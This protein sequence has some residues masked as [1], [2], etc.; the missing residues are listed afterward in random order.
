MKF[1]EI[2]TE[3]FITRKKGVHKR[4]NVR[5]G[6]N[7]VKLK[8]YFI[9]YY[10]VTTGLV[11]NFLLRYIMLFENSQAQITIS[12]STRKSK[13]SSFY[14]YVSKLLCVNIL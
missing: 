1:S 6:R 5:S 8:L 7:L 2:L 11:G 12:Q 10:P 13:G 14:I 4:I 3:S 9:K